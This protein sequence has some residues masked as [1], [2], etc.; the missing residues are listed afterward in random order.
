MLSPWQNCFFLAASISPFTIRLVPISTSSNF[1][2]FSTS[3]G[4]RMEEATSLPGSPRTSAPPI[5][6]NSSSVKI[7]FG[8]CMCVE[9]CC[10]RYH[11][12]HSQGSSHPLQVLEGNAHVP[13]LLRHTTGCNHHHWYRCSCHHK[14]HQQHL[15]IVAEPK[16]V[17]G[18]T[19]GRKLALLV[20]FN[21]LA[22]LR[23]KRT[24]IYILILYPFLF[25]SVNNVKSSYQ[26]FTRSNDTN[27]WFW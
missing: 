15:I 17:G 9:S 2:P 1:L 25:L 24:L 12:H 20:T 5:R 8:K 13:Q 16:Q 18:P 11:F 3:D 6:F 14:D 21:F 27:Q 26:E 19:W 4:G 7:L 23:Q 10:Q 22:F